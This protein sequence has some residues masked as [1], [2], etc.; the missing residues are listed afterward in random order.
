VNLRRLFV[1]GIFALGA[2]LALRIALGLVFGVLGLLWPAL[3]RT[4]TLLAVGGVLYGGYRLVS[5]ARDTEPSTTGPAGRS[6]TAGT[7][8][9]SRV[10][11]LKQ[12]YAS[13]KLS[14]E[15]LERRLEQELDTPRTDGPGRD[16]RRERE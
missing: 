4:V 5:Q 11:E 13:G 9:E 16:L 2:L 8:S 1:Y 14:E 3:V 10:E 7:E 12:R 6:D 15:E